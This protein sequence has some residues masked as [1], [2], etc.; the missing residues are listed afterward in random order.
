[1]DLQ[2]GI[3]YKLSKTVSPADSAKAYGSGM[4]DV[5]AT[6][7][8]I[9]FMEQT[10]LELVLPILE[11]GYNTVGIEV[12]IKHLK[13]TPIGQQIECKARLLEIDGRILKFEVVVF[14]E[15][16]KAGEGNHT[17]AI[18]NIEKFMAKIG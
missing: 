14:D 4:V 7:A 17:R 9:G 6:P 11:Q 12:N 2:T 5:L 10:C 16:G 1:M 8:M 3:E 15:T 13:A 18:V